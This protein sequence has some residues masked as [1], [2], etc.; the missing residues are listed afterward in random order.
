M[1]INTRNFRV[2][3][4]DIRQRR[5]VRRRRRRLRV[6]RVAGA[7]VVPPRLL[8]FF[9]RRKLCEQFMRLKFRVCV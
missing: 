9:D 7:K 1:K 8:V 5:R 4:W 2:E 6:A 3:Y